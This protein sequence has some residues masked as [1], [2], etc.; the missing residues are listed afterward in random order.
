LDAP[1]GRK[2]S[3]L[4]ATLLVMGGIVGVGI[5]FTPRIVAQSAFEPWAFLAVWVFGGAIAMCA[6]FTFAELGG[7]FPQTGG[8]FVYL[9]EAFGPFPAF[10]FGWI[11][12]LV[13]STGATAAMTTFCADMLHV[14]A[15]GVV[16]PEGAASHRLAAGAIVLVVT[17]VVLCG[18]KRAALVQNACMVVKLLA[19]AALIVV[20]LVLADTAGAAGP[21]AAAPAPSVSADSMDRSIVAG[22]IAALLPVFFSYG[23][24]QMVGYVAP[25]VVDPPR[26]IPRAI[27]VGVLGVLAVYLL[28]N[29]AFLSVLGIE[30]IAGD[31]GFAARLARE[32]LGVPGERILSL[33][34][35]ISALGV[36]AVTIIATPWLYVAMAREGLFFRRFGAL[37]PTTGVPALA[38][39]TQAAITV[40]YLAAGSQDFFVKSVVFV[41]WIFHGLV[42]AG[43]ILLRRRRPELPRPYASPLF[44]LGPAVYVVAAALVVGGTLW[45]EEPRVKLLGLVIVG[46]GALVYRPWR[47]LVG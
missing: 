28:A 22:M 47:R 33:A 21:V 18:I 9:R 13:V 15:P 17:G 43:L 41:E 29:V 27:V 7:S 8:W 26:T 19:L 11:V 6:A 12:L 20:G 23:G 5:F 16:G 42:A 4:D 45:L 38:L 31:A 3:A 10:L 30:G 39:V 14:V 1:A 46:S 35:A 44:P 25:E 40:V 36:C 2:L 32:A 34:M 37:H 24:W